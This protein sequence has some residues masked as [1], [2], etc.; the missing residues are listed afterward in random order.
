MAK[1]LSLLLAAVAVLAFAIPTVAGAATLESGG[2]VVPVGTKITGKST[3]AVTQTGLGK[4]SCKE[5][6]LLGKVT[7][8]SGGTV[9]GVGT[10]EATGTT[11]NVEGTAVEVTNI[12][13]SNIKS[14][15]TTGTGK[16]TASFSF[17]STLP[18][19]GACTFTGTNAPGTYSTTTMTNILK[20]EKA[21]LTASPSA[22]GPANLSGEF[23]LTLTE[24]GAKA[25]IT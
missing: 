25:E 24:G 5:V 10:G 21:T 9:E 23:A 3:N 2:S 1:K 19:V 6:V 22:C 7:T 18:V 11:C 15:A 20:I 13:L 17:K 14:N 12:V 4:L 8:N 16:G